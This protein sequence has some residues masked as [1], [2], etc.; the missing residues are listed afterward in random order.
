MAYVLDEASMEQIDRVTGDPNF[1]AWFGDSK[2]VDESGLPLVVY[3]GTTHD[4]DE[5]DPRGGNIENFHGK[6]AYFTS[7]PED[8]SK[9]YAGKTG[10]DITNRIERDMEKIADG[11]MDDFDGWS[12]SIGEFSS[13]QSEDEWDELEEDERQE[14]IRK[15]AEKGIVGQ[16]EG[17]I[18]PCFLSIQ[19]PVYVETKPILGQETFF[20]Y[21]YN[22][23]EETE[24][25]NVNEDTTGY[26]LLEALN[27]MMGDYHYE[28]ESIDEVISNIQT[29]ML[30]DGGMYASRF[31]SMLKESLPIDYDTGD[32]AG[33][34]MIQE[35]YR[36]LGFDGIILNAG[37]FNMA[38]TKNRTLHFVPFNAT[39]IKSIFAKE[40]NPNSP[41]ISED[42]HN[43]QESLHMTAAY[44]L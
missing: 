40:F 34:Q 25:E 21:E 28:G 38:G 3:H 26:K 31:E 29:H 35:I 24:E 36:A 4:F 27:E 30:D 5:F 23:D 33:G 14:I 39:Q 42:D 19:N 16:H 12:D 8:A 2:V 32:Q 44:Y 18:L 13:V 11:I 37:R 1:K 22:F 6:G 9:N 43:I 7:D 41:K 20:D 10:P 15:I 17:A